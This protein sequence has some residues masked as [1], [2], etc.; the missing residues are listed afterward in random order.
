M[1]FRLIMTV[2]MASLVIA[3]CSESKNAAYFKKHPEDLFVSAIKCGELSEKE[4]LNNQTCL[5]I[6]EVERP[7]CEHE[8]NMMGRVMTPTG[9]IYRC[10]ASYLIARPII[11]A[12]MDAAVAGEPD[13]LADYFKKHPG[14]K[15]N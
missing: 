2:I 5:A 11:Q 7:A 1:R 15:F 9:W 6:A 4:A 13:P 3:G 10:D 14:E 8:L 12:R